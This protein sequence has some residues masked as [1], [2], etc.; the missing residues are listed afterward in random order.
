MMPT[1]RFWLCIWGIVALSLVL[2]MAIDRA[3]DTSQ[4]KACV[5]SG[6]SWTW[7]S[8]SHRYE[9]VSGGEG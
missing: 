9:C 8:D 4:M 1:A 5:E 6:Q 3:A 2:M 7:D